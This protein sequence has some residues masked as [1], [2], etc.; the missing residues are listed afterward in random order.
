MK[1]SRCVSS[2]RDVQSTFQPSTEPNLGKF[3]STDLPDHPSWTGRSWTTPSRDR[4]LRVGDH[5]FAVI[6][7][8]IV[9]SSNCRPLVPGTEDATGVVDGIERVVRPLINVTAGRAGCP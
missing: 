6:A 9:R 1:M 8:F 3:V 7:R 2:V 4:C 5:G